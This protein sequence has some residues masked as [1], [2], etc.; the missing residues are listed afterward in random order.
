MES[1]ALRLLLRKSVR[2]QW[3]LRRA[4]I[5]LN[6]FT[7]CLHETCKCSELSEP[8]VLRQVVNRTAMAT[9]IEIM[10]HWSG[11]EYNLM[12]MVMK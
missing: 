6:P 2:L 7:L 4:T 9:G 8:T 12:I 3:E 10:Q 11:G 1:T 5:S